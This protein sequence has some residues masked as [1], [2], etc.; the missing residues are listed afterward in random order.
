MKGAATGYW[1]VEEPILHVQS[2][3]KE[4]KERKEIFKISITSDYKCK[5]SERNTAEALDLGGRP[6]GSSPAT[7]YSRASNMHLSDR[8][9]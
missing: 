9:Q 2:E 5:D 1:S 6:R 8:R 7:L 4:T 3:T